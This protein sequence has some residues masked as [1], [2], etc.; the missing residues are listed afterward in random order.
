MSEDVAPISREEEVLAVAMELELAVA[1]HVQAKLLAAQ[2]A[3][4]I[5]GLGRTWQR[6]SRSL[7]QTV[8]LKAKLTREREAGLADGPARSA[9]APLANETRRRTRIDAAAREVREVFEHERL[10]WEEVDDFA[11]HEILVD[12]S[13]DDGFLHMPMEEVV[14]HVLR[15]L[16][17]APCDDEPPEAPPPPDP[18]DPATPPIQDSA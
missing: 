7:R 5:N 1:K 12:L 3:D 18:A 11:A 6:V 15:R 17:V 16:G 8:A 10:D 14:A 9:A 13:R 2:D 4:E